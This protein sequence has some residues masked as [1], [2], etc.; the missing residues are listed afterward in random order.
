MAVTRYGKEYARKI[1]HDESPAQAMSVFQAVMN[2][3]LPKT[4]PDS[5]LYIFTSYQV[6]SDWLQMTDTYLGSFGY[7]RK[8]IL[9]WE[10]EGPGMGDLE[11]PWGMGAEFILF[12][13][14]GRREKTAQ[15][16]NNVI[17]TPQLRPNQLIHP[18][19]KPVPLLEKLITASTREGEF[20]VDPFAGSGSLVRA[21]KS[22]RRSAVG[23]EYDQK[24]YDLAV[25]KLET[26]EEGFD[27]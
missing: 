21:A 25:R 4:K 5:D 12:F 24:N 6:L 10:K 17:R 14:K 1:A 27:L 22:T 26:G 20:I 16:R 11:S 18:H 3:L 7:K 19:E 15:R 13:Q 9:I 2:V 23:I 8:A